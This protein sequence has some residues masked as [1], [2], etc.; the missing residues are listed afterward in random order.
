M[1]SWS[2]FIH[3]A[4]CLFLSRMVRFRNELKPRYLEAFSIKK[5]A[6]RILEIGCASGALC[7]Q[8]ACWYPGA[9]VVGID[10]DEDFV[11]YA[12]SHNKTAV[13]ECVDFKDVKEFIDSYGRFDYV[14]TH[15]MLEFFDSTKLLGAVRS[16]L[17]DSGIAIT[18]NSRVAMSLKSCF[19]EPEFFPCYDSNDSVSDIYVKHPMTDSELIRTIQCNGFAI[20]G[21]DYIAVP[22]II[23][24]AKNVNGLRDLETQMY[25]EYQR[26][27]ITMICRRQN[28]AEPSLIKKFLDQNDEK[29]MSKFNADDAYGEG[30]FDVDI[31]QFIKAKRLS[32]HVRGTTKPSSAYNGLSTKEKTMQEIVVVTEADQEAGKSSLCDASCID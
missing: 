17:D 31:L 28:I 25:R 32:S 9:K 22:T 27:R 3:S 13:F 12:Q 29:L 2:Q 21:V 18:I 23:D 14:I 7:H 16:A 6:P 10:V 5:N 30:R 24:E 8:L 19:W 26:N 20:E 1:R 4:E 11:K 15:S